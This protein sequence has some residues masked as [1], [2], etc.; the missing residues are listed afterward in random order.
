MV[1]LV[2][3]DSFHLENQCHNLQHSNDGLSFNTWIGGLIHH[4]EIVFLWH[5]SVLELWQE[6]VVTIYITLQLWSSK[7]ISPGF[8]L[9]PMEPFRSHRLEK[10]HLFWSVTYI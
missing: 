7:N 4:K 9:A 6:F 10:F 5:H 3:C 8:N 1:E 2:F